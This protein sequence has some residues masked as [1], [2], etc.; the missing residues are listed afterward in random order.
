MIS[1]GQT[2]VFQLIV[3]GKIASIYIVSC[4]IAIYKHITPLLNEKLL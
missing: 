1:D 4:Y 2:E 3:K